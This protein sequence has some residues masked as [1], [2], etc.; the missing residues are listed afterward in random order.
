MRPKASS[1]SALR[2]IRNYQS[3]LIS[4]SKCLLRTTRR[5]NARS[6]CSHFFSASLPTTRKSSRRKFIRTASYRRRCQTNKRSNLK[7]CNHQQRRCLMQR[8]IL[9]K[10]RRRNQRRQMLRTQPLLSKRT[11]FCNL[12][13]TKSNYR[14]TRINF[15]W[16]KMRQLRKLSSSSLQYQSKKRPK[17]KTLTV[18]MIASP[19][20]RTRELKSLSWRTWNYSPS[21]QRLNENCK[22][23]EKRSRNYRRRSMKTIPTLKSSWTK[24]LNRSLMN[25]NKR[26]KRFIEKYSKSK[27]RFFQR[28]RK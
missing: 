24:I 19:T 3:K 22:M 21:W 6:A 28:C 17:R 4:S 16:K 20:T 1:T 5:S 18:T 27:K 25:S 14:R 7:R 23:Q 15:C 26:S 9:N 13:K 12:R 2:S 8:W 11:R 10:K